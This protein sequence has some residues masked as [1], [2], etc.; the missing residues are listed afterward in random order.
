MGLVCFYKLISA[1]TMSGVSGSCRMAPC[2]TTWL[3]PMTGA[4]LTLYHG[5]RN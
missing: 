5:G 1:D 2:V 3:H 4:A